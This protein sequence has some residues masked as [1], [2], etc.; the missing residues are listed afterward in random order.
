MEF[1]RE[2]HDEKL[3]KH[4][5]PALKT[6]KVLRDAEI[7]SGKLK[8][9]GKVDYIFVTKFNEYIPADMKWSDPEHGAVRNHH[10]A[11]LVAYG[12]LI[13][14]AYRTVV[15]RAVIHY[16]RA[17]K[18]ITIPV[19]SSMKEQVMDTIENIYDM[20]RSGREPKVRIRGG[21]CES[22]NYQV[23]CKTGTARK[24][25]KLREEVI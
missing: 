21:R 22:C 5:I 6:V 11:Q 2:V 9:T 25:L 18:T 13:E 10:K 15:K 24:T 4:L 3:L 8:L 17:G 7:T 23:Y 1:G 19:T 20:I 16:I 12:L 14:E